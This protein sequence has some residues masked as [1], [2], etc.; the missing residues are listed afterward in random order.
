LILAVGFPA[1]LILAGGVT[2]PARLDRAFGLLAGILLVSFQ[3][4]RSGPLSGFF[5][6]VNGMAG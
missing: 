4:G 6:L 1:L 3:I 5:L 2:L